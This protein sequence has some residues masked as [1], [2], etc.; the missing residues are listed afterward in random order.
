LSKVFSLL[1]VSQIF[2]FNL[3]DM[4]SHGMPFSSLDATLQLADGQ[5]ST[6]DLT[7]TSNAMNLSLVGKA[8]LQQ[9]QL[10]L[11]MGVKPFGT[12]DKIVSKIPLAGWILTG[13]NKA[14]I[15]AHFRISGSMEEPE[16]EAIPVTSV[17]KKV[18]GIFQ[19]VL[20]LPG[21]VVTDV[22]KLFQTENGEQEETGQPKREA[23]DQS[24]PE[25]RQ[26][27]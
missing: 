6:E 12:V 1:N 10:D 8:D 5:L 7:V 13:K 19:R 16:V 20:G 26:P 14:L 9:N 24:I 3:P 2:T 22:G 18:L 27:Q 11:L 21:K 23:G 4:A 17:S 25:G 15:T